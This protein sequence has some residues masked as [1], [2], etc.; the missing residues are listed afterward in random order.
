MAT[1]IKTISID[2]SGLDYNPNTSTFTATSNANDGPITLSYQQ[3]QNGY[4]FEIQDT[5]TVIT[6]TTNDVLPC[7][8]Q[9]VE[10]AP[11]DAVQV[12]SQ[13]PTA[14]P[15]AT[16]TPTPTQAVQVPS[17]TPTATPTATP[18]PTQAEAPFQGSSFYLY[19]PSANSDVGYDNSTQA[20]E[21]SG[22]STVV[23]TSQANQT[24]IS[25]KNNG[26]TVYTSEQLN[27]PFNG[28]GKYYSN[29]G[30][31]MSGLAS[32]VSTQGI[33][34]ANS[35]T[36]QALHYRRYENLASCPDT[37]EGAGIVVNIS[38][39]TNVFPSYIRTSQNG[40]EC[41][42]LTA[43]GSSAGAIELTSPDVT[44][45]NNC[46]DCFVLPEYY[47]LTVCNNGVSGPD[48][49]YYTNTVVDSPTYLGGTLVTNTGGNTY[50]KI[51]GTTTETS[52]KVA[53]TLSETLPEGN[54]CP[55]ANCFAN[56]IGVSTVDPSTSEQATFDL[57]EAAAKTV[58]LNTDDLST[59]TVSFGT[60]SDCSTP[61]AGTRYYKKITEDFY[62]IST[63][64]NIT[65]P[66][67]LNCL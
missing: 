32:Q 8:V 22:F 41:L 63:N 48:N 64:G 19:K 42:Y 55:G 1:T 53:V 14:T 9:V 12:P 49:L 56:L 24:F 36:C 23:Y 61:Q 16:P 7:G 35:T 52:G 13:T 11:F 20:C 18:T 57:C 44:I 17:Q 10:S 43:T 37:I 3:L 33:I 21:G 15:T 66:Y 5:A 26:Y 28:G 67:T 45:F 50:Y 65:G 46:E 62:Y 30:T 59:A 2:F 47:K 4:P 40:S 25:A 29:D 38:N 39:T 27:I 31:P 34:D 60:D 6:I 51:A 54:N 58:Y